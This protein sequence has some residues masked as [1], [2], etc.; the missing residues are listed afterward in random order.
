MTRAADSA[1]ASTAGTRAGDGAPDLAAHGARSPLAAHWGLDPAVAYLNHGSY[2]AC[3]RAVLAS[4]RRW[5]DRLESEPVRFMQRELEPELDAARAE[6]AAFVGA[7]AEDL[8]FVPNAT[9]GVNTVLRSLRLAPGDELLTTDQAYNACRNALAL[10]AEEAGARVVVVPLPFPVESRAQVESAVL[11]AVTPRTRFALLDHVTSPTGLVLPVD[12]LVPALQARGVDCLVDGAHAPGMLPLDLRALGAAFYTGNCH[13]WLCAP[14]GVAL[15]HV[16]RDRQAALRPLTISHGASSPRRDRSRFQLEFGWTGTDDPSAR[17]AVR[18]A[19]AH[20]GGLL[21]GGW[22][23]VMAANHALVLAGREALCRALGIPAPA[24]PEMLGSLAAV[25]LPDGRGPLA[26]AP[27]HDPL[28]ERL[29]FEHRIE[30]PVFAWPA[31]PRRLLRISAQ[32]YNSP[33]EYA[34]LAAVLPGALAG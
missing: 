14:K 11:A 22:P 2:G 10:V 25:P 9:T 15:L 26:E 6:L 4:Q 23:A 13:K 24:P 19:L 7:D 30:V 12:T 32:L 28:Q 34:R 8:V 21:P 17:L 3:P 31:P 16:R 29:W 33:A 27:W 5:Q 18:D 20:V 1:S